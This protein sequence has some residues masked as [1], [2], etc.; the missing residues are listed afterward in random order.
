MKEKKSFKAQIEFKEDSDQSG[1]FQAVFSRFGEVDKQGDVTAAG[2]FTEGQAVRIAAWGHNW[3]ALPV[4]RGV[5]HQDD[6]KAWVDGNFFLDTESGS[7][8]YKT[9]KNLGDLQE[10][11]YGFDVVKSSDGKIGEARVRFLEELQVYEVS[12]VL[13]GAGNNTQTTVIKSALETEP[14]DEPEGEAETETGDGNASG[15]SPEDVEL[16][17]TITELETENA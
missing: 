2:A 7:E 17:I 15:A 12:P 14:D 10:W 11:S 8:T 13:I 9:V 5:I 4:G 3:G 16:L 1:L 6:E